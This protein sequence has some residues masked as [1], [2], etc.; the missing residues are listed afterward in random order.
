M[1]LQRVSW[2]GEA[3]STPMRSSD[4]SLRHVLV[5]SRLGTGRGNR[6]VHYALICRSDE[7]LRL[8]DLGGFD[9]S[10]YRNVGAGGGPVGSSQVTALL[11]RTRDESPASEY[12]VNLRAKL[13]GSCWVRLARP[14]L[15]GAA[16]GAAISAASARALEMDS[17]DWIS[18][19]SAIRPVAHSPLEAQPTLFFE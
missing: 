15:L 3:T 6:G 16:A 18:T 11:V 19:V 12:R 8:D 17:G 13:A 7:A 14:C 1:S 9:P 2:H 4:R 10:A 5:T